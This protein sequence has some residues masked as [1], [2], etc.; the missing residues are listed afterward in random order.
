[1]KKKTIFCV[2]ISPLIIISNSIYF[3]LLITYKRRREGKYLKKPKNMFY[4]F[5]ITYNL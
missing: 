3:F 1:M 4:L 5:S 2:D